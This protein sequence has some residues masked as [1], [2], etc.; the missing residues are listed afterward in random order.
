MRLSG[1]EQASH[2]TL[3]ELLAELQ[4]GNTATATALSLLSYDMHPETAAKKY[5]GFD[6]GE[7]WSRF[8]PGYEPRTKHY[9][10]IDDDFGF[11]Y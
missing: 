11:E 6:E 1:R 5:G 3:S 10:Y 9:K 2:K 8:E 4:T 7:V